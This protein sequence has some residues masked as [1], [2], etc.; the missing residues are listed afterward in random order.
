M[1]F[2]ISLFL[3][4]VI[5]IVAVLNFIVENYTVAICDCVIFG[6][7]LMQT[8]EEYEREL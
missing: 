6:S 4:T 5:G 1:K 8:I 7:L 3:T 2:Y